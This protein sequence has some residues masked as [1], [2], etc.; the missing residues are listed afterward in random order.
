MHN[1]LPKYSH[2][3]FD[4]CSDLCMR[5]KLNDRVQGKYQGQSGGRNWFDGVVTAVHEDGT[6]DLQYDDGDY[7]ESVAPR[8]AVHQGDRQTEAFQN[9]GRATG[10][11]QT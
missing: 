5:P 1:F 6:C 2:N 3:F 9:T 11:G 7:E 10:E 8:L 4:L